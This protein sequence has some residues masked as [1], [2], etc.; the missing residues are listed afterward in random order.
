ME[1]GLEEPEHAGLTLQ[2]KGRLGRKSL[3]FYCMP[4]NVLVKLM[5]N[6]GAKAASPRSVSAFIPLQCSLSGW[7]QPVRGGASAG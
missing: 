4:E 3:R 1:R 5:G 7:E 2:K 6:S